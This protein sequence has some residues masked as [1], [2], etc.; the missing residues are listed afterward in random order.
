MKDGYRDERGLPRGSGVIQTTMAICTMVAIIVTFALLEQIM[1]DLHISLWDTQITDLLVQFLKRLALA[2]TIRFSQLLCVGIFAAAVPMAIAPHSRMLNSVPATV[3]IAIVSVTVVLVV[4]AASTGW[5]ID[6]PQAVIA[7]A[8][9]L[10]GA[11]LGRIGLD[12]RSRFRRLAAMGIL[13]FAAMAA[14]VFAAVTL[15]IQSAPADFEAA[16][17]TSAEKRRLVELIQN[18]PVTAQ[19]K[20]VTLT[21]HDADVLLAWGL[22][23]GSRGRKGRISFGPDETTIAASTALGRDRYLNVKCRTDFHIEQGTLD[24]RSAHLTVGRLSVPSQ[25]TKPVVMLLWQVA[26]RDHD[27]RAM[28]ESIRSAQVL[29]DRLKICIQREEIDEVLPRLLTRLG[30]IEDVTEE[31]RHYLKHLLDKA[32]QLPEGD[33][34]FCGLTRAAFQLAQNRSR[35]RSPVSENR[36]AVYA[37]GILLGHEKV[38]QLVGTVTDSALRRQMRQKRGRVTVRGRSDWVRHYWVSAALS[39][40]SSELASDAAGLLKEEVDAGEGGSGFSFG[41]LLADRAGTALGRAAVHDEV[42]ARRIQEVLSRQWDLDVVFPPAAD[43]PEGIPDPELQAN[44][45]GVQGQAFQEWSKEIDRRVARTIGK[46]VRSER[47]TP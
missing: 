25:I 33:E 38:E 3:V 12:D 24:L 40:L 13:P 21:S 14:L 19:G 16:Q 28:T 27:L 39:A 15:G 47:T 37:L 1:P 46:Q 7:A 9:C 10:W 43:L 44:Y 18:A 2:G 11:A 29:P 22:S 35:E 42:T 34:R 5:V 8:I 6:W 4:F 26:Q 30:L 17:V 20:L 36:A 23:L 32:D 31:T 45:G 41:D